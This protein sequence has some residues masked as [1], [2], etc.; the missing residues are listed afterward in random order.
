MFSAFV[1]LKNIFYIVCN[2]YFLPCTGSD[3]FKLL[4]SAL[5]TT[6]KYNFMYVTNMSIYTIHCYLTWRF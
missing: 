2:V 5:E 1:K 4:F 6:S 3:M